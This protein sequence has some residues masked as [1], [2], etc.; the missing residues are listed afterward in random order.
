[1]THN[2]LAARI[3][4]AEGPDEW[5]DSAH[6]A[7]N[8]MRRAHERGTGCHLTADM[9]ASLSLTGFGEIWSQEDPRARSAS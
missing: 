9:I 8:R 4:R 5:C 7:L 6:D 2:E 3:E 1:M